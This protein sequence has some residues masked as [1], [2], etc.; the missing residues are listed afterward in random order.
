MLPDLTPE[1]TFQTSRSSGPGGQ[2]VNK[3]ASRVEVWFSIENSALLT[4]EQKELLLEKLASRLNKEGFLHLASQE[5]RSQLVN[6]ELVVQKLHQV[7]T[8]ALHRPKPRKKTRPSRASVQ[9]RL[10]AKQKQGQKK[11]NRR[12]GASGDD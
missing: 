7:L 6:K 5:D 1:L 12:S 10:L 9:K 3:V 2:N 11:A 4:Q 8:Q